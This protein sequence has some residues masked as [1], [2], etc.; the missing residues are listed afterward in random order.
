MKDGFYETRK[1]QIEDDAKMVDRG[2]MK[3]R[4]ALKSAAFVGACEERDR[5]LAFIRDKPELKWLY[6]QICNKGVLEVLGY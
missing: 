1:E 6:Q 2:R 3:L 4:D 5:T